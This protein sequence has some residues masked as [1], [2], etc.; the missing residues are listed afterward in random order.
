MVGDEGFPS[1]SFL[2]YWRA[3]AVSAFGTY[4]TMFA[5][6]TLVVLTL[7]GSAAQV[8]W[9]N[10]ARWLP[11]LVVGV[12]VGALVDRHPRRPDHDHH[13]PRSGGSSG[14]HPPAVVDRPAVVSGATGDRHGVRHRRSDQRG[15]RDVLPAPPGAA[16]A[17]AACTR[18]C[19]RR[20]R[21][22]PERRPCSRRRCWS[23]PSVRPWRSWWTPR[24][25][26]ISAV[27]LS[28]IERDASL[29]PR[30]TP[31]PGSSCSRSATACGGSTGA[32]G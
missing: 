24:P 26:S 18:A 15:G 32:P 13:R 2:F 28:R 1:R 6:Q 4:I 17:S 8:G 3:N 22:C 14:D 29:V 9:L 5:L 20:R 21:R 16:P 7:H 11:Y 27:T 10:S 30:Q 23:A 31:R 19:R 25:M 12:V